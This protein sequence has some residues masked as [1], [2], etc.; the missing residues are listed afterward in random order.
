MGVGMWSPVQFNLHMTSKCVVFRFDHAGEVC[1]Y[2][3]LNRQACYGR[4]QR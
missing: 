3:G 4:A 2:A 1:E